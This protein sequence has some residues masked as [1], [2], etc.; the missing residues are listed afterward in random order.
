MGNR[1]HPT[2]SSDRGSICPPRKIRFVHLPLM[3]LEPLRLP[4]SLNKWFKRYNICVCYCK[5]CHANNAYIYIYVILCIGIY[6][7]IYIYSKLIYHFCGCRARDGKA[8]HRPSWRR[9]TRSS[10][11]RC[12]PMFICCC[13]LCYSQLLSFSVF[14][15]LSVF[16]L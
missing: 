11:A 5:V 3:N 12:L 6:I 9:C 7:Y 16:I 10:P 2:I 4:R 14:C 15:K 8:R 13:V 1:Q